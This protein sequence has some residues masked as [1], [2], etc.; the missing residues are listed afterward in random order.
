MNNRSPENWLQSRPFRDARRIG[1]GAGSSATSA[2][3]RSILALA[4]VV[5]G[6]GMEG[7]RG[8]EG[9]GL[10]ISL[11]AGVDSGFYADDRAKLSA[12]S[13]KIYGIHKS[14]VIMYGGSGY[15][16]SFQSTPSK[17]VLDGDARVANLLQHCL[18]F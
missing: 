12:T 9:G 15:E 1:I 10:L 18:G 16:A 6:E 5:G 11:R 3:P 4:D 13:R 17:S 8:G 2:Q 14:R 7:R